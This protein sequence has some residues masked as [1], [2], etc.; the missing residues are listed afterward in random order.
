MGNRLASSIF[1]FFLF[2]LCQIKNWRPPTLK[3]SFLAKWWSISFPKLRNKIWVLSE[4]KY[5]VVPCQCDCDI[6]IHPLLLLITGGTCFDIS[7]LF[8]IQSIQSEHTNHCRLW[9]KVI[10]TKQHPPVK[11]DG[12]WMFTALQEQSLSLRTHLMKVFGNMVW[13]CLLFTLQSQRLKH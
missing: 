1:R 5:L 7:W 11:K 8:F 9:R 6:S 4:L 2:I 13:K 10:S 3:A 12:K